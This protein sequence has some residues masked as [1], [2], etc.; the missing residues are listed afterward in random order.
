M[1][2]NTKMKTLTKILL[3][4]AITISSAFAKEDEAAKSAEFLRQTIEHI[5]AAI[6]GV[7]SGVPGKEIAAHIKEAR[8]IQKAVSLGALEMK[9]NKS[10][11]LLV[12]AR[13]TAKKN[14]LPETKE[15]LEKALTAYRELLQGALK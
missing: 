1:R 12:K 5:E 3:I 2:F 14:E 6:A 9:R 4:L 10:S 8:Q 11:V 7:D 15:I 13:R